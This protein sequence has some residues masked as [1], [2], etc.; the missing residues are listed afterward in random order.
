MRPTTEEQVR[1]AKRAAAA[2]NPIPGL[3]GCL[4]LWLVAMGALTLA[5]ALFGVVALARWAV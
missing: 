4:S 1:A 2:A 5:A 3:L